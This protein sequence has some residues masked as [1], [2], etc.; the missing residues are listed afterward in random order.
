MNDY[1]DRL[2]GRSLNKAQVIQPR[3]PAIFEPQTNDEP[4]LYKRKVDIEP[5]YHSSKEDVLIAPLPQTDKQISSA[6]PVIKSFKTGKND[7]RSHTSDRSESSTQKDLTGP[8]R[9]ELEEPA[10]SL[11]FAHAKTEYPEEFMDTIADKDVSNENVVH[12][13]SFEPDNKRAENSDFIR[14]TNFIDQTIET[15]SR[16]EESISKKVATGKPEDQTLEKIKIRD[17]FTPSYSS[18]NE[19]T[20]QQQNEKETKSR[21]DHRL[22][23]G[24]NN[25]LTSNSNIENIDQPLSFSQKH[26][27]QKNGLQNPH[28]PESAFDTFKGKLITGSGIE[29]NNRTSLSND[30]LEQQESIIRVNIGRIEVRAVTPS[31]PPPQHRNKQFK[32][33]LSLDDYLSQRNG[34]SR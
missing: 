4:V 26:S 7:Q 14:P 31:A 20:I 11:N 1:I 13:I 23:R 24:L 17:Q 3:L 25:R 21:S 19:I 10:P 27:D 32:P 28:D 18:K 12:E 22:D 8:D 2:I 5:S 29:L 6:D 33:V 30:N 9:S 16:P 15:E 34:G